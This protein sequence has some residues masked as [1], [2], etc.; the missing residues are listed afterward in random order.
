MTDSNQELVWGF[1]INEDIYSLSCPPCPKWAKPLE[2][3]N[4]HKIGVVVWDVRVNQVTHLHGSQ[5]LHIL[6]QSRQSRSWKKEGLLVGEIAYRI[7][8]PSNRKSKSKVTDQPKSEPTQE[9]GWCLTNTIQ[10]TTSQAQK[11]LT[12]LEQH[13]ADLGKVIKAEEAERRS[14]LGQVY[15]FILS[16]RYERKKGEPAVNIGQAQ[17][18]NSV[19]NSAV[20][21]ARGKYLTI[22][23]VA[24]I[25]GVKKRARF[26]LVE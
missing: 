2:R 23:Q 15:S 16:W 26:F 3:D 18:P 4:W 22:A 21:I 24:D 12:F 13:E 1:H 7:V 8:I 14:I 17:K 9:D 20:A 19:S 6:E 25:C 11:F 5:A 10:L